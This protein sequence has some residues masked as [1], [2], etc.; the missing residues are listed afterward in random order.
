M[1][2]AA[3]DRAREASLRIAQILDARRPGTTR[4]WKPALGFAGLLSAAGLAMLL[5]APRLVV[6]APEKPVAYAD[7]VSPTDLPAVAVVPATLRMR[8]TQPEA[9]KPTMASLTTTLTTGRP[10]TKPNAARKHR[11]ATFVKAGAPFMKAAMP[12]ANKPLVVAAKADQ[13]SIPLA[14]DLVFM[15]ETPY[16][17]TDAAG[18]RVHVWRVIL[19]NPTRGEMQEGFI[20]SV[21]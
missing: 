19:I 20:A 16:V 17:Q 8:G 11:A 2:Q 1:A 18:R 15:Q 12:T 3:V 13:H 5:C 14:Q 10:A 9:P 6:F 4:I 21:I 7:S